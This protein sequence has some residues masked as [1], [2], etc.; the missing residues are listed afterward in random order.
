MDYA[1]IIPVALCLTFLLGYVTMMFFTYQKIDRGLRSL[2]DE[3]DGSGYVMSV[4]L[5]IAASGLG[6][7]L[8]GGLYAYS[9]INTTGV[10][11]GSVFIS[12][13]AL[14]LSYG[15]LTLSALTH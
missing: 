3:M 6:M 13:I 9:Q 5:A 10:F 14:A 12:S 7:G 2:S 4:P 15:G 11:I 1:Q 8:L